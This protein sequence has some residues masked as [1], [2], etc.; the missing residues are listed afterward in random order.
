MPL[1]FILISKNNLITLLTG[2]SHRRLNYLHRAA[3]RACILC[4][5]IHALAWTPIMWKK[6]ELFDAYIQWVI[7]FPCSTLTTGGRSFT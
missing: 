2:I 7:I 6:G 5:W 4:A 3:A 1:V